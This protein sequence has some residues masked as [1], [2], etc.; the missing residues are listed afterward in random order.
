V[1]SAFFIV[2]E[3][4]YHIRK[5]SKNIV[6]QILP[7]IYLIVF[8]YTKLI[9]LVHYS[10]RVTTEANKTSEIIGKMMSESS[11][12]RRFELQIFLAQTQTRNLNIENKF[13]KINWSVILGVR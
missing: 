5:G 6:S 9:V 12:E 11:Y 2:W 10:S 8:Q 3:L 1:L 13:F 7:A 4:H